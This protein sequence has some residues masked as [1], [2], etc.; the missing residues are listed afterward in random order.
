MGTYDVVIIGGGINGAG[1]A[2]CAAAAGFSV[3]VL[4]KGCIGGQTSANS[5]KLIHGGLRYL[6]T[7][8]LSLVRKSLAERAMLLKLAPSL[9]KPIPF[10]IPVYQ[11][12]KRNKWTLRVGLSL[13]ALLS[14]FDPLARFKSLPVMQWSQI[15]GLKLQGLIVVYQYWD[16]QTDDKALTQAVMDSAQTLGAKI[17]SNTRSDTIIHHQDGCE[18]HYYCEADLASDSGLDSDLDLNSG[19]EKESQTNPMLTKVRVG[20]VINAAGPWVNQVLENVE[21]PISVEEVEYIQGSHLLLDIAPPLGVLY[22]ES[23]FDARVVFVMPWKGKTLIGT[24]EIQ[25]NSVGDKPTPTRE[26]IEY[27]L[28]IYCHYFPHSSPI[29][30]LESLILY[31][32]CG[33]RVLPKHNSHVFDMPRDILLKSTV[34]H[35]KIMTLYGGKLTT[36]RSTAKEVVAWMEGLLGKRMKV[37]HF[38]SLKLG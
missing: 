24:T 15:T 35:P 23:C 28:G 14:D 8:Q 37:A 18:V 21:P 30:Q 2:Q 17:L 26:E 3:L 6:E 36:Y 32:F 13:Y 29:D 11:D 22:L 7:G 19:L 25:L 31:T 5:S 20:C 33:V 4:E 16:A 12:S 34:S 10:Y 38:D 9:V 1:I 27:L